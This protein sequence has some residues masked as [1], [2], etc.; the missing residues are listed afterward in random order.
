MKLIPSIESVASDEPD[1]TD[2]P[3]TT[4]ETAVAAAARQQVRARAASILGCPDAEGRRKLA[5]HLA[6]STT[7]SAADAIAILNSSARESVTV[8]PTE[9]ARSARVRQLDANFTAAFNRAAFA[10]DET[11]VGEPETAVE[12]VMRHYHLAVG[13]KAQ[14]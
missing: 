8:S 12:R 13:I 3:V 5:E 2:L 10:I 6:L 7:L 11:P 14:S 1:V 9:S 4:D